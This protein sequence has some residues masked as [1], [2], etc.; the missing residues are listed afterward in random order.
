MEVCFKVHWTEGRGSEAPLYLRGGES[1]EMSGR[2]SFG[3]LPATESKSFLRKG[4]GNGVASGTAGKPTNRTLQLKKPETKDNDPTSYTGIYA[5][6]SAPRPVSAPNTPQKS[7][8]QDAAKAGREA[9]E[10]LLM[11]MEEGIF[12]SKCDFLADPFLANVP[13]N[14][15]L[16]VVEDAAPSLSL[17]TF[18]T[19]AAEH[20]L[21][22]RH[23]AGGAQLRAAATVRTTASSGASP[24]KK[25]DN[26]REVGGIVDD[27]VG[28]SFPVPVPVPLS[29]PLCPSPSPSP[30][31]P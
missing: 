3:S 6:Q 1:L 20:S 28:T 19:T 23:T 11:G 10:L 31:W 13:H 27:V 22:T 30:P 18:L 29:V 7:R 2:N 24:L 8:R 9:A 26:I 17:L 15:F 14:V 25:A 21:P 12:T 4:Q 5:R 16:I